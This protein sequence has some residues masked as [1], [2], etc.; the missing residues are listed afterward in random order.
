M[1]PAVLRLS[2]NMLACQWGLCRCTVH[3]FAK[4]TCA[5]ILCRRGKTV[6]ST[7]IPLS[8]REKVSIK[9][10]RM[11]LLTC[12]YRCTARGEQ[13]SFKS[14]TCFFFTLQKE[15]WGGAEKAE[16]EGRRGR[17]EEGKG[18]QNWN[19]NPSQWIKKQDS[20]FCLVVQPCIFPTRHRSFSLSLSPC[21]AASP[22]WLIRTESEASYRD[23][24]N[25]A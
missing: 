17:G 22:W 24:E 12:S 5:Y 18:R 9:N 14:L 20:S 3:I 11:R 25:H 8:L 10:T 16:R 1:E 6:P 2:V 19:R 21:P 4:P 23:R 15:T 7:P 13:V